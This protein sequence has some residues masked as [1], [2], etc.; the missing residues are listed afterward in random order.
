MVVVAV[1]YEHVVE[2]TAVQDPLDVLEV[3]TDLESGASIDERGS[4]AAQQHV[5]VAIEQQ[6]R[7]QLYYCHVF[8]LNHRSI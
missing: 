5:H 1:R 6:G 4:V 3:R 7:I 8:G 2:R